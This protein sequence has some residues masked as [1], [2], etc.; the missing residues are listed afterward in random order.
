M[1][2]INC[3]L[4]LSQLNRID[5]FVKKRLLISDKYID[6][7]NKVVPYQTSGGS[8]HLHRVHIQN[9]DKYL[10][11]WAKYEFNLHYQPLYWYY[12]N[13]DKHLFTGKL[14]GAESYAQT[15]ISLPIHPN[16]ENQDDLIDMIKREYVG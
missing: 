3:A 11:K 8:Y 14:D 5:E 6:G 1:S 7:L 4:G 2:D 10:N 16:L 12:R 15:A 13:Y 9:R